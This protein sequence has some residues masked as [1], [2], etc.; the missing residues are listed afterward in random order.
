MA[1]VLFSSW[2]G[3]LIDERGKIPGEQLDLDKLNLP[4]R[5]DGAELKAFVGWSGLVIADPQVDVVEILKTYFQKVQQESCGRCIPCRVGSKAI[6]DRLEKITAGKGNRADLSAMGWLGR[7]MKDSSLCELGQSAP[8][9][10]LTALEHFPDSFNAYLNGEQPVSGG[11]FSYRSILTA[12]CQNGCPA[13]VNIPGYIRCIKEGCYEDSLGIIREKTPL[14]GVLGRVCVHPCES[15]CRRQPVDEAISIRVLKRFVADFAVH[16]ETPAAPGP[17]LPADAPKIAVIGAGPAGLNA[18]YQLAR[19]GYRVTIYEALPVAGG[20]LAVGIPS[21]RLPRD[22]LNAEIELVKAQGVEIKLNTRIGTDLTLDQL[23]QD[24]FKAICIATGLHLSSSMGVEGE[25]A[26]YQGFIPGVEYLR[27]VNLNRPI[28]L[29]KKMA[30]IG[31]GNVAMDCARSSLRMGVKEV[32]LVYRRSRKEMPANEAEIIAAAEEGVKFV[33]LANPTRILAENGRVMGM[34]CVRMELGEPDSSGRRRP[35]PVKGSEFILDV[36]MIVPAI[37]Q[38]ADFSFLPPDSGVEINKRGTIEA[39]PDTM[40]TAAPDLFAGG[41][42]VLGAR[43]V[44]EAIATGNKAAEAIDAYLRE[45]AASAGDRAVMER[46]TEKMGVYNPD[47]VPEMVGGRERQEEECL[48]V[49]ERLHGF[50]ETELGFK[51]PLE[52][53]R[54]AER[55]AC[56]VRLGLAVF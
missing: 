19:K 23:R 9:P 28:E 52:A 30:V 34:E 53:L 26:G 27:S 7:V 4:G 48:P 8:L 45:G 29:G 13:H 10:L 32:Y 46:F 41:D 31:G 16:N 11:S 36:D 3:N 21:Y 43:T 54:E 39:D 47:E 55:C 38:V 42:A 6:A 25:E 56:C 35:V 17:A 14:V 50:I 20:M 40:A 49:G 37:G 33:L 44:I 18:A 1:K 22:I 24:G 51:G 12:P 15:N 5:V 2:S